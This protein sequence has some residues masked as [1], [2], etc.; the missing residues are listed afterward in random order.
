MNRCCED[1]VAGA[2][3]WQ[4][5]EGEVEC[6]WCGTLIPVDKP[7]VIPIPKLGD[8]PPPP[9]APSEARAAFRQWFID[10]FGG[11]HKAP[12]NGSVGLIADIVSFA[13]ERRHQEKLYEV[14]ALRI[15]IQSLLDLIKDES[16]EKWETIELTSI[17]IGPPYTAVGY[18]VDGDHALTVAVTGPEG[19]PAS[20]D[21]AQFFEESPRVLLATLTCLRDPL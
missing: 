18:L 14:T 11:D 19:H 9:R 16:P 10:E 4:V 15:D 1:A 2:Q 8:G 7:V 6:E 3:R 12:I 13:L 5:E 20:E 17:D 21:L